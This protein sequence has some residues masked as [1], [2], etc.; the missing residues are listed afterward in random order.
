LFFLDNNTVLLIR[1]RLLLGA[2]VARLDWHALFGQGGNGVQ[3][4][5]KGLGCVRT[6]GTVS[7][8]MHA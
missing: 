4:Q 2:S 6:R 1:I 8:T 5:A 7:H 3:L